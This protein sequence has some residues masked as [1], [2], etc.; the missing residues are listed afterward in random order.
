MV[1]LHEY[2]FKCECIACSNNFPL[3]HGLKSIDKK[4]Y[5]AAKK[6]KDEMSK[7]DENQAKNKFKEICEIIQKHHEKA[8]PSTEITVLQECILQCVSIVIK[9]KLLIS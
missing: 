1:L 3:F 2:S 5:K 9:P 6:M 7:I 4:I 8:F